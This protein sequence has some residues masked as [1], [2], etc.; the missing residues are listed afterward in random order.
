MIGLPTRLARYREAGRHGGWMPLLLVDSCARSCADHLRVAGRCGCSIWPAL[1][2]VDR[3]VRTTSLNV[4]VN[5][6][7][8]AAGAFSAAPASMAAGLMSTWSIVCDW[9]TRCGLGIAA[10]M[11]R[12]KQDAVVEEHLGTELRIVARRP[13]LWVMNDG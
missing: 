6:L 12:W 5:P 4:T 11:G 13:A 8:D 7:S 3:R 1:D 9:P 2:G 10:L